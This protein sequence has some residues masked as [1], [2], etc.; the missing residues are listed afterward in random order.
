MTGRLV[1]QTIYSKANR[2]RFEHWTWIP[3][4]DGPFPLVVLLH[5]VYDAGGFVWWHQG[6]AAVTAARLV[7]DGVIPPSVVVMAGDTGAELGTGYCDWADGTAFAE[8]YIV[9]ELLPWLDNT[10]PLDGTRAIAGLSMGGYGALLLALR[11]PG[12][13]ASA[14]ATSGFFS[15]R[16]LFDFV[17]DATNR[18]W[19]DAASE[20]EHDVGELLLQPGRR[21]QLAIAFDCGT[22][23]EL[24]KENT[25]MHERLQAAGVL[26]G[27]AEH[28][29]GHTWDYWREHLPDHLR[30]HAGAPGPLS[31]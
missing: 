31:P 27:Y 28:A 10:H 11:N 21:T 24:I 12:L 22:E 16:R 2:R 19:V 20:A 13:F 9:D 17:P 7:R 4:G 25:S 26:H 3:D 29:G 23:D 1:G 30:F 6:D 8:T 5:G 15:P 14:S 18:M